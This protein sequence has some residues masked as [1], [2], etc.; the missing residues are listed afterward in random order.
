MPKITALLHTHNDALR[1]GRALESLR[2]CDE[3]LIIDDSSEDET[4]K[5]ARQH[6]AT[7]KKSI[8]GVTQGAYVM[9]ATYDWVLCL[10]PSEAIS[11]GLEAA[12]FEWKEKD[13]EENTACLMVAIRE[14]ME[15]GWQL[16]EPEVRLVNRK[17]V[18]WIGEMPPNQMCDTTLAGEL[19]R[20]H[21]P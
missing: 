1:L 2:A 13:P 8:S 3:L 7:L 21:Q 9:D 14:E 16:R 18:N 5:V 17:L 12:L 10:L 15:N 11:E 20:F 19:L 4:D 6:G